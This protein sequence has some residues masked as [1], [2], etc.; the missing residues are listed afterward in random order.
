VAKGGDFLDSNVEGSEERA[1]CARRLRDEFVVARTSGGMGGGD[2]EELEPDC[3]RD[4]ARAWER[5]TAGT[6]KRD[7]GERACEGAA[8]G[9]W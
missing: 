1:S 2:L 3:S 6:P 4:G 8:A 9:P 5:V 7:E